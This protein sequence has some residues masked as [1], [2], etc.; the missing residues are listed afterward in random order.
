MATNRKK[1]YSK[2]RRK[3]IFI[4]EIIVLILLTVVLFVTIWATHKFSLI[5]HQEVD[6]AKLYTADQATAQGQNGPQVATGEVAV[7]EIQ[8]VPQEQQPVV[9]NLTGV[10]IFALAGIDTRPEGS[11]IMNSDTMIIC[12]LNHNERTIKLCSIYRDTYLN[13]LEDLNGNPDCYTKANSAY[14]VGGPTQFL[15]MLNYNLDLS[16]TEYMTVNFL[17][18]AETVDLLGGLDIEMTREE[19]VHLNNY[20]VETSQ[21]CGVPYEEIQLPPESEFDGAMMRTFHCNGSQSVSYARIR[22]TSGNDF[23]RASRQR[24]VLKLIK[25]KASTADLGTLDAI[26]NAVLPDVTTNIDNMKLITLA[27]SVLSYELDD[28]DQAGFPFVM[29]PDD[30]SCTGTDCI[31]PVTLQYNVQ[32]LHEFLFPDVYYEPSFNVQNTSYVISVETG[33]GEAAIEELAAVDYGEDLPTW[34]QEGYENEIAA[35]N[36]GTTEEGYTEEGYY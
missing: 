36:A 30:G 12:V 21:V 7:A 27:T 22:Y 18:L 25:E 34:W 17:A 4:I 10:D 9:N 1:R 15:S 3:R 11:D 20:N 14:A 32:L 6:S 23:R 29:V 31:I 28:D 16:I 33:Y 2:Q 8:E 24:E 26:L 13:I 19:V 35:I 5:N